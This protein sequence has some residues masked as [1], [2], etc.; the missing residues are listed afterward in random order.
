[1]SAGRILHLKTARSQV[2]GGA[3]GGMGVVLHAKI[4]IDHRI[5]R[6]V[7]VNIAEYYVP[8]MQTFTRSRRFVDE[9]DTI[10]N[11]MGVEG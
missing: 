3:I 2:L 9:Y 1:L 4:L 7:N 6:A 8:V 11:P 10:V 5:R